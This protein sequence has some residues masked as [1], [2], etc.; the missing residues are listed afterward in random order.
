VTV[1][2]LCVAVGTVVWL[3]GDSTPTPSAV[4]PANPVAVHAVAAVEV[5]GPPQALLANGGSLWVATPSSVVRLNLHNGEKLARTAIPTNGLEAGLAFGGGSI[6]MT[7][8]GSSELLRIDPSKD[9]IVAKIALRDAQ[10]G[11][12]SLL[13]GGVTFAF[14]RVWVSR[15]TDGV[16]GN[17]IAV[18]PRTNRIAASPITVGSGPDAIV[19][20]F[21]SLW[22]DNTTVMIGRHAPR[23]TYPALS[24]IDPRTRHVTNEP[25]SGAPTVAFGS[26]WIPVSTADGAA[27]IRVSANGRT[28]A[29]IPVPGVTDISAGAGRIWAISSA[30]LWQID[31]STDRV[32]GRPTQLGLR[33]P[34]AM[35][36]SHQQLWIADYASGTVAHF[37]LASSTGAVSTGAVG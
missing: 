24:R 34:V 21:G 32:I 31:P 3:K 11:H 36:V 29:R 14:G 33:Q 7:P 13:G 9:R 12:R 35:V 25:F 19:S 15:V 5:G 26:L 18:D 2:L 4:A 30:K 27:V 6:W 8:T 10:H 16:R 20:A 23:Q 17:V 37:Q 22:V 1:A 28:L